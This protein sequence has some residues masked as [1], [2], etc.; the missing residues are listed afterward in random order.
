MRTRHSY[1]REHSKRKSSSQPKLN[2]N[3][4][5]S[6]SQGWLDKFLKRHGI[7]QLAI[8]GEKMSANKDSAKDFVERFEEMI[9]KENLALDQI[10]NANETGL[11]YRMMPSKSFTSKEEASAPGYKKSKDLVSLLVY[12][13]ASGTYKLM[14]LLIRNSKKQRSFKNINVNFLPVKYRNRVCLDELRNI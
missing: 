12:E 2:E 1:F 8:A 10:Y 6:A 7:R 5:F 13:N 4:S 11:F 14:L 3:G 9:E